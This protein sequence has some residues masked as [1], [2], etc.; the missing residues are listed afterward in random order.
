LKKNVYI[1]GGVVAVLAW[2]AVGLLFARGPQPEI[3]VPA[4]KLWALGP[5][6]I[7]N[8]LFTSW[9]VMAVLIIISL[10]ATRGMTLLPGG[11]QNFVEAA[12]GFLVD[13]VEDIAGRENGR[14]FFVVVATIFLFVLM[15]NWFGLLPFFN[16]IGKTEDVGHA[17]FEEIASAHP[18]K[19]TLVNGKYD[20]DHKFAGWKSDKSGGVVL[21]KNKAKAI[22][23]TVLKGET[24]GQALDRYVVFLAHNFAGFAATEAEQTAPTPDMVT[25]AAAALKAHADSAPQL[26]TGEGADGLQSP[27]LGQTVTGVD[28]SRSQKMALI[29]PYF[30][31]VFSDVN[32]T[33]ALAIVAFI[34]IEFW[35]FQALGFGYL[36][37][38]FNFSSPIDAFVGMLELLSEFIR[39][40]S[41]AFRLFGNI[42]AGEVLVLMLTF[43]MPFLFV[44]IIYGLELFVGFIQAA[45]FALLVLVFG[46]MAVEHHGEDE[47]HEGH[48]GEDGT[49]DAHNYPGTAQAH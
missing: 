39:I 36:K 47:H 35:G 34:V 11:L 49:A 27:V 1:V 7:T 32:N 10:V 14:R 12:I 20:D 31:G 24:P 30:R 19:L 9:V 44:D 29:V 16:S 48:M 25:A 18:D 40:I 26:L 41:F 38:F 33:L 43:L 42:F 2:L 21:V 45:V 28:F 13:Q 15:S 17:V 23:F 22:D 46:T 4:E 3:V 8:T 6:N 5:L 37:K